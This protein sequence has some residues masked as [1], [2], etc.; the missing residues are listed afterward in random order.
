MGMFR[1]RMGPSM[2]AEIARQTQMAQAANGNNNDPVFFDVDED[3]DNGDGK[4][5]FNEFVEAAFENEELRMPLAFSDK[6]ED[7]NGY[8]TAD[9]YMPPGILEILATTPEM[10]KM[11]QENVMLKIDPNKDGKL[12]FD[13]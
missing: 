8:L 9:E 11:L 3:D 10:L 12:S 2:E 4:V 6:D 7:S 13:E 1:S 5:D